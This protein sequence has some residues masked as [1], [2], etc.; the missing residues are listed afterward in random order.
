MSAGL[1]CR[2]PYCL[3]VD[4][5]DDE[6]KQEVVKRIK[7]RG[8]LAGYGTTHTPCMRI[9]SRDQDT[10]TGAVRAAHLPVGGSD[11][12]PRPTTTL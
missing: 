4:L 5:V 1:C 9:N 8:R 12:P 7:V 6:E 3:Q 10:R 2:V 11:M